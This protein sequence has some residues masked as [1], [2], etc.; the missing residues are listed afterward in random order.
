M[1]VWLVEVPKSGAE[2]VKIASASLDVNEIT[3]KVRDF[4]DNINEM[5][6]DG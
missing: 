6:L 5:S 3:S 1:Q 2:P 4:V